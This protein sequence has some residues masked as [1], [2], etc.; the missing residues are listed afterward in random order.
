MIN[1]INAFRDSLGAAGIIVATIVFLALTIVGVI[2]S[3]RGRGA[4][5]WL[6]SV[7]AFFFGLTLG[8]MIGILVFNSI[9]IMA[10]LGSIFAVLL[11]VVVRHFKSI[12]YF[13]GIGTLGWVL[14]YT[15]TSEM[16]IS[17]GGVS[18]NTLLFIDLVIAVVMG[19]MAAC[20]SKY[21]VTFITSAS[22][23]IITAISALALLGFYFI[24]IKTWII[25]VAVAVLGM[26]IQFK[27]YDMKLIRK[28][29]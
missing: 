25:A 28:R 14:A 2:I 24:D 9:I 13:I 23:G 16:Y 11:V 22:G 4:M 8:S 12:G 29:K 6:V 17:G 26:L 19:I 7:S 3:M 10:V 18:E 21:I 15:V 1:I 20:R 5:I 27:T